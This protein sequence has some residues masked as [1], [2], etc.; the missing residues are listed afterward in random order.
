MAGNSCLSG[1]SLQLPCRL[2]ELNFPW[3]LPKVLKTY[4]LR[5]WFV[6]VKPLEEQWLSFGQN[7]AALSYG[8]GNG[9][10]DLVLARTCTHCINRV[11]ECVHV[12]SFK[13]VMLWID[14][15]DIN[16]AVTGTRLWLVLQLLFSISLTQMLLLLRGFF[17]LHW[18]NFKMCLCCVVPPKMWRNMFARSKDKGNKKIP[19]AE[20]RFSVLSIPVFCNSFLLGQIYSQS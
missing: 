18:S 2:L 12:A 14:K 13:L 7:M 1:N 3:S 8:Q 17:L 15:N 16:V 4:I 19:L 6:T 11:L 10:T 9:V 20:H 5:S